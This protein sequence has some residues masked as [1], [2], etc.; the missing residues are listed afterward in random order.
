MIKFS[1]FK[2]I[3]AVMTKANKMLLDIEQGYLKCLQ[4][5][6]I[7]E[8]LLVDIKDYLAN[9]RTSLDY[10]WCKIS[11]VSNGYF[12]IA[13]SEK[14]FNNKK[15]GVDKKYVDI[16]KKWQFYDENNWIRCFNL[17]RNKNSHVTLIP[18]TKEELREFSI[19]EANSK[20]KMVT[21][22]GCTF[23]GAGNHISV[24]GMPVPIDL[25]TQSP[26]NVEGLDIERKI[27]V[28]FLFDGSSISSDFPTGVSALPFL[29]KSFKNVRQILAE[30]EEVFCIGK[31]KKTEIGIIPEE[32]E[33][34]SLN[35]F[36]IAK[37]QG[38]NTTTEK[39]SYSNTGIP[40]VRANNVSD[41]K[42][43]YEDLVY[44]DDINYLKIRKECRPK[45]GDVLYT[46]IG[47]RFGSAALV[48][49]NKEFGIAWNVMR[50]QPNNKKIISSFLV[51][52]LNNP[53]NKMRIRSLNA[54]ST[55]PFV[56]GIELGKTKFSIPSID[57]QKQI[58]E[59]L[60]SLDDKIELN[61]KINSNL[62]KIASLLFKQWFIDF[63]FPNQNGK[64]YKSSGGKM[65]NSEWGE[66]PSNW[67]T[68][69]F[70]DY[71]D[72]EYG[73]SSKDINE[74]GVYPAYG[75]GGLL[76]F[77]NSFD[78]KG[79]QA[80]IGCRGTCGNI[81]IIFEDSKI[82]HNSLIISNEWEQ[83][84]LYLYLKN[85]NIEDVI[86]GSTQ[87]QITIKDLSSLNVL[88][89]SRGVINIFSQIIDPFFLNIKTNLL[90][91]IYLNKVRDSLLPRLMNGKIRVKI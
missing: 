12:P 88:L 30:L 78:Y 31:F 86:T 36:L 38:V 84:F 21:F 51:Y 34:L 2:D 53:E 47:S 56:S 58:A 28:N 70:G 81:S 79:P 61:R 64:P 74:G 54:S 80:I 18:Q 66:I 8:S 26:K 48:K 42:I 1:K 52:L 89:P 32:W 37:N 29:K 20:E 33:T 59:I 85:I 67:I 45:D 71:F 14:E 77:S 87:P 76:G 9:L 91:N 25:E 83:I 68:G 82:T 19:K 39:V 24:G 41:Y 62:E 13:N 11:N 90:E 50:M 35:S 3:D 15:V 55:M 73:K 65:I 44:V 60:S 16:L 5:E 22:S 17:F 10:L 23:T 75:A 7:P 57:E 40:I 6:K 43:D 27:W 4:E 63:D 69:R 46:P 72:I 49:E